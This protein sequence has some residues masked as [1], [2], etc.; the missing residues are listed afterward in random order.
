MKTSFNIIE[1]F[2]LMLLWLST[3]LTDWV[4]FN[5]QKLQQLKDKAGLTKHDRKF[6]VISLRGGPDD[7]E[8][9]PQEAVA[10]EIAYRDTLLKAAPGLG[11]T[12]WSKPM[13]YEACE[14]LAF[15]S[16]FPEPS[17][18]RNIGIAANIES[19]RKQIASLKP[20]KMTNIK[21]KRPGRIS[22]W[23]KLHEVIGFTIVFLIMIVVWRYPWNFW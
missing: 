8:V 19:W 3:K 7:Y 15:K 23:F 9:V 20:M 2:L 12:V 4:G 16:H 22:R 13:S 14:E 6:V 10:S 18:L 5:W 21:I 17:R 1:W 11:W